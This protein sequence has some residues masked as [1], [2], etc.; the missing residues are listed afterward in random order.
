MD[1][2]NRNR[3]LQQKQLESLPTFW[4]K[5]HFHFGKEES[6]AETFE[7]SQTLLAELSKNAE[8]SGKN[9]LLVTHSSHLKA[10][11]SALMAL[12]KK[13]GIEAHY[14]DFN[15]CGYLVIDLVEKILI[16]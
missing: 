5:F 9:I 8:Y 11:F 14:F 7:R 4:D 15:H 10:Y 12:N 2:Y 1:T 16:L 13:I 6:Y 3:K